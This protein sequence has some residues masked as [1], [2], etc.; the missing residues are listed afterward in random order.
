MPV[1]V[2]PSP[3]RKNGTGILYTGEREHTDR[4]LTN[5]NEAVV[6]GGDLPLEHTLLVYTRS[7]AQYV[8]EMLIRR[9]Q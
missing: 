4:V 8:A 5:F 1:A 6:D 3:Q 7:R 2:L 9:L